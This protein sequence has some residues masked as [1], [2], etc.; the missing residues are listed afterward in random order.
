M[1][2][3]RG[4]LFQER[5]AKLK[6]STPKGSSTVVE[7]SKEPP[8]RFAIYGAGAIGAFLGAKLSQAGEDVTLIARSTLAAMRDQ[9]VRVRSPQGDFVAHP[10]VVGDPAV[11]GPVDYVFLT[12]KAPSLP[13]IVPHMG[14]LLGPETAVVS[15]QNGIPWWYFQ[16]YSGPL[17]GEHL[18]SVD[19][20]G[21][22][23]SA[24]DPARVIGC[25][26]YPAAELVEPGVVQHLEGD[27][28]SIGELD[29]STT[30]RCRDLA[31]A[32]IKAGLKCP[33]RPDIRRDLWVKLLGNVAFNPISALTRAT[34]AEI[35]T[36]PETKALALAMMEEADAVAKAL[37]VVMPVSVEQRLAGAEKVGHHKTSMLLDA[38]AGKPLE[39]ES[40]V[41]VVVELGKKLGV[42]T[43]HTRAVYACARLL[44]QVLAQGSRQAQ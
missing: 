24:I 6:L 4:A 12:V 36:H 23:A 13:Q 35:A 26:I 37:G 32:L 28:F 42:E 44:D 1:Q 31:R 27:R 29:G 15:A 16:R 30:A 17:A 38:E 14:P 41:G 3:R 8:S 21:V 19:P 20:G 10:G 11:V 18:E 34:M 25:V 7:G 39:L 2:V 33:I 9:G 22:I 5:P 40:I 43:P